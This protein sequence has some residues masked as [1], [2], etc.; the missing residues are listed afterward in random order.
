[1]GSGRVGRY[2]Q[3]ADAAQEQEPIVIGWNPLLC[4]SRPGDVEFH[5]DLFGLL[6]IKPV[7]I[8]G[9]VQ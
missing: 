8:E 1:M 4:T 9:M 7:P 5:Q 3:N 2:L 6:L